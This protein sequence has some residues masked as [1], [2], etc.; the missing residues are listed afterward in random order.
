MKPNPRKSKK[1]RLPSPKEVNRPSLHGTKLMGKID[2]ISHHNDPTLKRRVINYL[3]RLP[4]LC[5]DTIELS[6][7]KR[8]DFIMG[9]SQLGRNIVNSIKAY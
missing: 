8:V 3:L 9:G 2:K 4:K 1:T 7:P 5:R 6:Q